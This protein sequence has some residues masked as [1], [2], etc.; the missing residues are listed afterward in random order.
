MASDVD[1]V[2]ITND[3]LAAAFRPSADWKTAKG[4]PPWCAP[5]NG[6][7]RTT[8]TA[9]IR[10]DDSH[11]HS[12]RYQEWGI[13]YVLLGGDP[14][15]FRCVSDIDVSRREGSSRR[16]VLRM[17]DGDWN[18]N[19]NRYFGEITDPRP[20]RLYPEVYTGRLPR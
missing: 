12:R 1:Y 20:D 16:Y 13:K 18:A 9:W 7:T 17:F 11:L 4:V 5:R 8:R 10:R 15:R 2:I 6:S 14:T 19:H 3:S